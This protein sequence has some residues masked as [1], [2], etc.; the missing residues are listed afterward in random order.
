MLAYGQQTDSIDDYVQIGEN[1]VLAC[2]R[3]FVKTIVDVFGAQYLRTVNSTYITQLLA[4][5]EQQ[6]IS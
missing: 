1:I 5:C 3:Q 6:R 4:L 2:L